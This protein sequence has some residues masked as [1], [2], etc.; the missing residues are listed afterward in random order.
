MSYKNL[1]KYRLLLID[2][3]DTK[4]RKSDIF[5]LRK[6]YKIDACFNYE[7][8]IRVYINNVSIKF[9]SHLYKYN[10]DD[11]SFLIED[12][13][14]KFIESTSSKSVFDH[15][16]FSIEGSFSIR[17]NKCEVV[18]KGNGEYEYFAEVNSIYF[19]VSSTLEGEYL[20]RLNR[21]FYKEDENV[22]ILCSSIEELKSKYKSI[23][24]SDR[25]C[26]SDSNGNEICFNLCGDVGTFIDHGL[27][28]V[29]YKFIGIGRCIDSIYIKIGDDIEEDI[30]KSFYGVYNNLMELFNFDYNK[31]PKEYLDITYHRYVQPEYIH[32]NSFIKSI[33]KIFW[34]DLFKDKKVLIDNDI[35]KKLD[36]R[37]TLVYVKSI[38]LL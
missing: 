14:Q 38:E 34:G 29:N 21:F 10:K 15:S 31:Y 19:D 26:L 36:L 18:D 33:I 7:D 9:T 3:F 16:I 27:K 25:I 6:D 24:E 8:D 30:N 23:L 13:I 1:I 35:L 2:I 28:T 11:C 12:K 22:N 17:F 5:D 20:Y 32:I 4:I 37:D